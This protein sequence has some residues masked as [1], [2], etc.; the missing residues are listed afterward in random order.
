MRV[1]GDGY[2][3]P[4]SSRMSCSLEVGETPELESLERDFAA[5]G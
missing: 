1:G 3:S 2:V 4:R 5:Q